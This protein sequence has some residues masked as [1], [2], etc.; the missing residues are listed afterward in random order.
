MNQII[1]RTCCHREDARQFLHVQCKHAICYLD[2]EV[3]KVTLSVVIA[4]FLSSLKSPY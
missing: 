4:T 1:P 3:I 2:Q